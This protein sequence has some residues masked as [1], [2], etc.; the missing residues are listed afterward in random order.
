MIVR[1]LDY[2]LF[3]E[4]NVPA[5]R[6]VAFAK[7][8]SVM[9]LNTPERSSLVCLNMVEKLIARYG[10]KLS[11]LLEI[12]SRVA[13]GEFN[14]ARPTPDQSNAASAS[15]WELS[16]LRNHYSPNIRTMAK[17]LAIESSKV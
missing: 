10:T 15:L 16:L 11:S 7:R 5:M 4:R 14:L 6:V 9:A 8:L 12:D 1:S 2:I 13:N 3:R 17:E